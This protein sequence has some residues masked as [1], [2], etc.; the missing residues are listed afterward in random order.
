MNGLLRNAILPVILL[1]V[2]G[3]GDGSSSRGG[4]IVVLAPTVLTVTPLSSGSVTLSW[5]DNSSNETGFR[6]ERSSD[7]TTFTVVAVLGPNVTGHTDQGL[8]PFTAYLY[9]VF[10]FDAS[11][12]PLSMPPGTL[13]ENTFYNARELTFVKVTDIDLALL[14][15]SD[16]LPGNGLLYAYRTD[17]NPS[18]PSGVRLKNGEELSRSLTVVS[19]N[20][21]YVLGDFNTIGKKAVAIIADAV[22]LLS[23]AWDDSKRPGALPAA[24]NTTY[25]IALAVGLAGAPEGESAFQARLEDLALFH[26]NW[27]GR[28]ATLRGSVACLFP[29]RL[30]RRRARYADD[31]ATAPYYDWAYDPGFNQRS[32]LP[33]FTPPVVRYRTVQWDDGVPLPFGAEEAATNRQ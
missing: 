2:S 3:C 11:G 26:E 18:H 19:E 17:S 25:N 8:L 22:N 28:T 5:T 15:S 16:R 13:R 14:N 30:A 29:S 31:V 1:I 21:V 12:E 4:V 33:P 7:G 20:P 9:R 6:V 23:S 27:S 10:A 24:V 32:S